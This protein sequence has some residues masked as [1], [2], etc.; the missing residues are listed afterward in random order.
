M[1]LVDSDHQ[2]CK[3]LANLS[4]RIQKVSKQ[5]PGTKSVNTIYIRVCIY[6][7]IYLFYF[8]FFF[9]ARILLGAGVG[10]QQ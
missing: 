2:K 3:S 6:I 7:Y 4:L 10:M 1:C 9:D 5:V 8:I